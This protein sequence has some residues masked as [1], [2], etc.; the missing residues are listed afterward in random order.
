VDVIWFKA[1]DDS[2]TLKKTSND[3]L[4]TPS[5][6][7][8]LG[9]KMHFTL[10]KPLTFDADGAVSL[11]T[12]DTRLPSIAD[13]NSD[14]MLKRVVK[15]IP[16]N[17][18]THYFT[19]FKATLLFKKPNYSLGLSY[20][21]I[22]PDYKS[23]GIYF[24]NNDLENIT[25]TP[26]FYLFKKKFRF[27]GS[28]GY[29]HDNL[30]HTKR[31]TSLRTIWNVSIGYDPVS[32]FGIDGTWSNFSTSQKAGNVPLVD[33]LKSYNVNKSLSINPRLIFVNTK[34]VHAVLLSFNQN[35]YIDRNAFSDAATTRATTIILN[36]SMTFIQSQLGL[37]AGLSYIH[38]RNSFQETK[39]TG[40][41]AGISKTFFK[42]KFFCSLTESVQNS[43]ILS[44][45]GWV[46]NTNASLRYQP[47]PHHSFVLQI[48]FVNN[49]ISDKE[50]ANAYNQSKGDLSY[51]FT[52]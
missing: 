19:A 20:T 40:G 14:A 11:Y 41:N 17:L 4:A 24:I 35:D 16:L 44:Q 48:Y 39:M 8:A 25:F 7:I 28:G 42:N 50:A 47:H 32:W 33:T 43:Y 10:A 30:R 51:V 34:L 29:Q 37:N 46:Y 6:N 49:T 38:S 52:F 1:K 26:S 45:S 15:W 5:A 31:A 36:Y 18:S 21:R 23:M 22:D 13:S 9:I 27:S 12:T 3:S 2:T